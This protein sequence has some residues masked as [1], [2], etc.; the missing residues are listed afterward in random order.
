MLIDQDKSE[1]RIQAFQWGPVDCISKPFNP[2]ELKMR[3]QV[4]L[5]TESFSNRRNIN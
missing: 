5:H 1:L 4:K 2:T 3:I